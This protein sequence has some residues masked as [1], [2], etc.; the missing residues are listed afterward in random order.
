MTQGARASMSS[1]SHLSRASR[2]RLTDPS[3]HFA[4]SQ[5]WRFKSNADISFGTH[6][7]GF[8]EYAA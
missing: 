1:G 5:Q 2:L 3:R 8:Y 7:T 6:A 4:A